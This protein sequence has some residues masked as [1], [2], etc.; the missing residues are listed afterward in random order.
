MEDGGDGGRSGGC[1]VGGGGGFHDPH[2]STI[3]AGI[4]HAWRV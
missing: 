1:R 3:G 4:S 2:S